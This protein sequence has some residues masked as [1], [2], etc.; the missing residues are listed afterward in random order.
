MQPRSK[1]YYSK[2]FLIAQHVSGDTSPIIRSSKTVIAASGFTYVC[3]SRPLWWL[4]HR[5]K[6]KTYVKPEA[7]ITVFELLIMGGV[8]P[9]TCWAINPLNAKLNPI[10]HL[11]ALL[12]AHPILHVSRIRV[13]KH[14]NNKFYYTVAACWFFLWDLYYDA[15]IHEHQML[16]N[17]NV[18]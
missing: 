1:I 10:C 6:P 11:L 5:R 3:G 8:S 18:T 14:W 12:G 4:C 9:E 15:R 2:V 7:A 17:I 16:W 13:K